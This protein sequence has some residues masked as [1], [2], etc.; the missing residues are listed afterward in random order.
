MRS[1]AGKGRC[2]PSDALRRVLSR[3][4]REWSA[5][6]TLAERRLRLL[7]RTMRVSLLALTTQKR[8]STDVVER[9]G[10]LAP[11]RIP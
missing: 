7:S 4:E 3:D 5:S 6:E 11:N 9:R 1:R 10:S 8:G 2:H